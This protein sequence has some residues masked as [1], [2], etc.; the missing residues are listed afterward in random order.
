[1]K[2]FQVSSLDDIRCL[3]G[4]PRAGQPTMKF[5]MDTS[6]YWFK[7]SITRDQGKARSVS[8]GITPPQPC[9]LRVW[10]WPPRSPAV[11]LL[12]V[13]RSWGVSVMAIQSMQGVDGHGETRSQV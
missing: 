2:V 10:S 3:A 13:L 4:P 6:K 9:S 8:A 11:L 5:V 7:P 12:P 1:M